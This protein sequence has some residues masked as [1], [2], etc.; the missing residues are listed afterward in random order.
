MLFR[1]RMRFI[2]VPG[3]VRF[4]PDPLSPCFPILAE[5]DGIPVDFDDRNAVYR[6]SRFD[7]MFVNQNRRVLCNV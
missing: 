4:F 1:S 6:L 5:F 2:F 3:R 7:D